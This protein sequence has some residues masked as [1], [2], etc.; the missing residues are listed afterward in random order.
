M[1][2]SRKAR[3]HNQSLILPSERATL[4]NQCHRK[5]QPVLRY[6]GRCCQHG[7]KVPSTH[8]SVSGR[9]HLPRPTEIRIAE[10]TGL[11]SDEE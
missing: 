2:M 10:Y 5:F 7:T 8:A 11:A 3:A 4:L 6:C 9:Y 1:L